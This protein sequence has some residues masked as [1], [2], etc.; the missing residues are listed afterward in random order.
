MCCPVALFLGLMTCIYM[1]VWERERERGGGGWG[2]GDGGG[3][4]KLPGY[5]ISH[6]Y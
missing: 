4:K 1:C 6:G 3:A 5:G 2:V